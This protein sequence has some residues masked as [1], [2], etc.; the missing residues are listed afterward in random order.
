MNLQ[1]AFARSK[2]GDV[3][4]LEG[5]EI[6]NPTHKK[7]LSLDLGEAIS[8][9]WE[10]VEP[11]P[12]VLTAEEIKD[13]EVKRYYDG[14]VMVPLRDVNEI[15]IKCA[16][17]GIKNGRIGMWLMFKKYLDDTDNESCV[18]RFIS[19]EDAINRL[20]PIRPITG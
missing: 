10:I 19:L 14:S 18:T 13:R 20:K 5:L 15:A 9:N 7:F 4:K 17:S 11:E 12:K 2:K 6:K 3:L 1:T 8:E 16:E